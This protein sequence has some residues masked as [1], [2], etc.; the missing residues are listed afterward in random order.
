MSERTGHEL[1][2]AL[3]AMG[4]R[5]ALAWY[6]EGARV[7]LSG[8]VLANWIIK[9]VGHLA[10]EIALEPGELVVIAAPAHWKRLVLALAS[11]SLGARVK[12]CESDE[13]IEG[14]VR[15]LVTDR[16]SAPLADQ[17]DEVLALEPASL[18]MRWPGE[19]PALAHDWVQEVRAH[20]DALAT[21]LSAW[22]G[23]DP[24]APAQ[25]AASEHPAASEQ[26][27]ALAVRTDGVD[28]AEHVLA[29]LL[30]G[31][32]IVG[33]ASALDERAA[34]DEGLAPRG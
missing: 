3:A 29:A 16:P 12:L 6:G 28:E 25:P 7:E 22:G 1:L 21:P 4:P 27:G 19:L 23:P 32:R 5:P 17:A 13:G 14:E 8:A 11:W 34:Q 24:V 33:P 31:G 9:S 30:G 20:P 18:A 10:D 2:E 15:V 26:H